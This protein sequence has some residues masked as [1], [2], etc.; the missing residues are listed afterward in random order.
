M[1]TVGIIWEEGSWLGGNKNKL[2]GAG[3][4]GNLNLFG[5]YPNVWNAKIH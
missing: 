1:R 5:G 3:T 2:W 4:D